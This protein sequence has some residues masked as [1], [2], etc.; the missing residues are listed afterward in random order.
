VWFPLG[1]MGG[2]GIMIAEIPRNDGILTW[3]T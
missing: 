3:I 1:I 2:N